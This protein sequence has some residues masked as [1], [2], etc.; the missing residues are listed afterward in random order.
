[1]D[2]SFDANPFKG[3]AQ[4]TQAEEDESQGLGEEY[5]ALDPN[6]YQDIPPLAPSSTST[7]GTGINFISQS[8][9]SRGL[10]ISSVVPGGPASR[11]VAHPDD[12]NLFPPGAELL[13]A[14]DMLYK[15]DGRDVF[16]M[17]LSEV[18]PLLRGASGTAVEI[19]GVIVCSDVGPKF[20]HSQKI[21]HQTH[22]LAFDRA[23]LLS[24]TR[25]GLVFPE[26]SWHC[27][28]RVHHSHEILCA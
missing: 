13:Q 11:A 15:V 8:G 28:R 4:A 17:E 25:A 24:T 12:A 3:S 14:G 7:E 20:M 27:Q 10:K 16:D 18:A 26:R 1:M 21:S 22:P 5:Y 6:R 19:T 23:P 9:G 2:W